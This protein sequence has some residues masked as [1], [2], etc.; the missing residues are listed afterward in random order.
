MVQEAL[1]CDAGTDAGVGAVAGAD[2]VVRGLEEGAT[3]VVDETDVHGP[4]SPV[5]RRELLMMS[6]NTARYANMY[7]YVYMCKY[8]F[9]LYIY[10]LYIIRFLYV[11]NVRMSP[12]P[13]NPYLVGEFT[14]PAG[15]STGTGSLLLR[16]GRARAT[17]ARWATCARCASGRFNSPKNSN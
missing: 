2:T 7:K 8:I 14:T 12:Y 13:L 4:L 11:V 15:R 16:G 1:H 10:Y 9:F 5:Q 6:R 17:T 3:G